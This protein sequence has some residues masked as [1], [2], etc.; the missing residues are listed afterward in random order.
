MNRERPYGSGGEPVI[1]VCSPSTGLLASEAPRSQLV[2]IHP[3]CGSSWRW[4]WQQAPHSR[5]APWQPD[6]FAAS[7][8]RMACPT[9]STCVADRCSWSITR[10]PGFPSVSSK[11][12]WTETGTT[13]STPSPMTG[14][15]DVRGHGHQVHSR[16]AHAPTARRERHLRRGARSHDSEASR[17]LWGRRTMP[18]MSDVT[19]EA[20]AAVAE[21]TAVSTCW[22]TTRRHGGVRRSVRPSC[23]GG[24]GR[25]RTSTPGLASRAGSA[26]RR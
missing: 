15:A 19:A 14:P 20:L 18:D 10:R 12:R 17:P 13:I 25:S 23:C 11:T 9:G 3:I 24:T 21:G 16:R 1:R 5:R 26:M 2:Q 8:T 6:T 22:S 7:G 4:C